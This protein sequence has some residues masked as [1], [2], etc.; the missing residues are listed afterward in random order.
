MGDSKRR[1]Q[2]LGENYGSEAMVRLR[3]LCRAIAIA[4]A[5]A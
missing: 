2:V 5:R 1:K 3:E 4:A